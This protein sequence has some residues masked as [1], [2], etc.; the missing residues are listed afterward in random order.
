MNI[1]G[2]SYYLIFHKGHSIFKPKFCFSQKLLFISNQI[3]CESSGSS[4]RKNYTT[5]LGHMTKMAA[6]PICSKHLYKTSPEPIKRLALR[7]DM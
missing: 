3:S 5:G 7:L 1:K 6:T 4:E 2:Q